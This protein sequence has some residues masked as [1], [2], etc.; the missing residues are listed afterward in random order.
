MAQNVTIDRLAHHIDLVPLLASWFEREWPSYYG[1][2]GKAIA[3]SDLLSFCNLTTLPVGIVAFQNGELCGAAALKAEPLPELPHLTPW[4]AAGFVLPSLRRCGIGRKLLAATEQ[5]A[6]ELGYP[7]IYCGTGSSVSL[8]QRCG[9]RFM[10]EVNH[11][12][13]LLAVY[14]KAL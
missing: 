4:A 9:W 11:S 13:E 7:R 5:I 6:A 2:N 8:L 3:R 10:A 1:V 14:E 12:G